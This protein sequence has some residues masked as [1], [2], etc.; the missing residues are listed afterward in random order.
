M[1]MFSCCNT[2]W[3]KKLRRTDNSLVLILETSCDNQ[4]LSITIHQVEARINEES[5]R[6][7]HYLDPTTEEPIVKVK[8]IYVWTEW[9]I[10]FPSASGP[11]PRPP[12]VVC[13]S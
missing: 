7:K 10:A 12:N 11:S 1:N 8:G 4:E 3:K 9:N 5:E 6:A 13:H 2:S